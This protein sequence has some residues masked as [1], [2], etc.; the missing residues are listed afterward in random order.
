MVVRK[1]IHKEI[2][3]LRIMNH[4]K[5]WHTRKQILPRLT[6]FRE[7]LLPLTQSSTSPRGCRSPSRRRCSPGQGGWGGTPGL[8][9]HPRTAQ[10]S[11]A[12]RKLIVKNF[13]VVE[14][15]IIFSSRAKWWPQKRTHF[16]VTLRK[17]A[18]LCGVDIFCDT[19]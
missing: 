9:P 14:K 1:S 16:L 19:Q 10:N 7:R 11:S 18:N 3:Q 12:K 13:F 4:R 5:I 6:Q 15:K 17:A 2:I 8:Q